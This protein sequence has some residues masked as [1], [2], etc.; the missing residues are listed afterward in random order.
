MAVRYLR[1]GKETAQGG[2]LLQQSR[3]SDNKMQ[4]GTHLF[5]KSIP[6]PI[7]SKNLPKIV[8][9]YKLRNVHPLV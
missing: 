3:S 2:N 9:I 8:L 6:L 7:S 1:S 4:Q 5:K